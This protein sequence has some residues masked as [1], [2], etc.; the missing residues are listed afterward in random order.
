VVIKED[1]LDFPVEPQLQAL[2]EERIWH[3]YVTYVRLR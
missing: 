1:G 3:S 2:Y